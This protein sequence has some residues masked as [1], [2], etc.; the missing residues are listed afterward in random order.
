VPKPL[1]LALATFLLLAWI[2]LEIF[3]GL[4]RFLEHRATNTAW[5]FR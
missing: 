4:Q 3:R 2:A 1:A 5:L